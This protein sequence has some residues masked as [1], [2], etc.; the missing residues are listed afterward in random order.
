VSP[1]AVGNDTPFAA[2]SA[3][4]FASTVVSINA[5]TGVGLFNDNRYP[6]TAATSPAMRLVGCGV[7]VRYVGSEFT[8]QGVTIP[9]AQLGPSS[10]VEGFNTT[11]ALALPD[12]ISYTNDKRWHGTTWRPMLPSQTDYR[13]TAAPVTTVSNADLAVLLTGP[14]GA[15][16]EYEIV[17]HFEMIPSVAANGTQATVPSEA[18]SHSDLQGM[19]MIREFLGTVSAS[20]MGQSLYNA[21]VSFINQHGPT[22]IASSLIPAAAYVNNRNLRL[23]L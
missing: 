16:F 3:P 10:T 5:P 19:S 4:A 11:V 9:V 18:A 7:R 8:R 13:T 21:G 6:Y 15:F 20:T 14:D 17:R 1:L 2:V 22:L 12:V 23:E